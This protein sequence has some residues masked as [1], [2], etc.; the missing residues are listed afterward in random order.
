[1]LKFSL[2]WRHNHSFM[3]TME[4]IQFVHD[5]FRSIPV[6]NCPFECKTKIRN[7]Y[8]RTGHDLYVVTN[9]LF[10]AKNHC[11]NRTM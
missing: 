6:V 4:T 7:I 1:M 11:R 10:G 5:Q 2:W 3:I 9:V 8:S